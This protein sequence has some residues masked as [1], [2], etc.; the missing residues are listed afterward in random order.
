MVQRQ[1]DRCGKYIPD[2]IEEN[3]LYLSSREGDNYD[4]CRECDEELYNQLV[5][6]RKRADADIA[7]KEEQ[8]G[9]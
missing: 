1:C 3:K 2:F 7:A 5:T 9:Q 4:L 6:M 8:D